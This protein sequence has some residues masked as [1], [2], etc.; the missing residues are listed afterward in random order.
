M[1]G[2]FETS[3]S[4]AIAMTLALCATSVAAQTY[5]AK[6]VRIVIGFAPGG[7]VDFVARLFSQKFSESLGQ[8]FVIENRPGAATS[9]SA[10]RVA[11]APADG[12]TLLLL[13]IST[14]VHSGSRTG[15]AYDLK[16]DIAAVSQI[17][18]GPLVLLSHPSLPVRTV[19]DLISFA[20]SKPGVLEWSSPGIGS[21][22]HL[23]GELMILQTQARMLH[24]PFK[25]SSE[26]VVAAATGQV[27][28]SIS[29]LAAAQPLLQGARL[30][31]LAVTTST[32]LAAL[33]DVPTLGETVSPGYEYATWY[34]MAGP[35]GMPKDILDRLNAEIGRIAQLTDVK[36]ALGRQGMVIQ[37]GTPEQFASLIVRTIDQTASVVKAAGLKLN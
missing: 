16:R 9:I 37:T 4:A 5:P 7:A 35:A 34:G 17:G 31:A 14:A 1:R 12:Y 24:V 21:A 11:R 27:P 30:R 6:P 10:E 26:S 19:G 22:N 36:E 28:I 3:L 13:P 18:T 25:G 8:P 2:R 15:L 20:R 32:R 33:P 23:A 29:S